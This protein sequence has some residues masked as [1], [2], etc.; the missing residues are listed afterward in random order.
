MRFIRAETLVPHIDRYI[1]SPAYIGGKLHYCLGL[2]PYG[3]VKVFGQANDQPRY[4][5]LAYQL[6]NFGNVLGS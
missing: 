1:R 3:T 5:V 4:I 2:R 6:S